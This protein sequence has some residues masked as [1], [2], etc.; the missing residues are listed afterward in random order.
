M[1]RN[2]DFRRAVDA[3]LSGLSVSP[4]K[5]MQILLRAQEEEKP[6]KKKISTSL[7]IVFAVMMLTMAAGVATTNYGVLDFNSSQKNNPAYAEH[8]LTVDQSFVGDY[9]TMTVNE[10]IFDS[11][12]LS[13]TMEIQPVADAEPV[14]IK[15]RI[16][17][18][19]GDALLET[20]IEGCRGGDFWSGFWFPQDESM[21]WGTD[22]TYGVDCAI[23]ADYE[24]HVAYDAQ[25]EP[26]TWQV[27]FDV[28]KPEWPVQVVKNQLYDDVDVDNPEE[29]FEAYIQ[30][31]KDAI[32]NHII[33]TDV[34]GGMPEFQAYLPA[35]EGMS[36]E[37]WMGLPN[38][39]Q[40][41]LSGAFSRVDMLTASFTTDGVDMLTADLPLTVDLGE[42][43]A[44]LTELNASF[45][46]VDYRFEVHKK[47][48][49]AAED[50]LNDVGIW[51]FAVISPSGGVSPMSTGGGCISAESQDTNF[52]ASMTLLAPANELT[53]V[54]IFSE[55]PQTL[56]GSDPM[57]HHVF[58]AGMPLTEEQEAMAF[59]V[60]LK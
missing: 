7:V 46:R 26:V 48:G 18:Q 39:E 52:S 31:F 14:F 53:F 12:S 49:S 44:T 38:S 11:I 22:G 23:I 20:D 1:S 8:I 6:V 27:T 10:A 60:K 55:H 42:Y 25:G 45:A 9:F 4:E 35:P 47:D 2:N 36:E 17:A 30:E 3:R 43:E 59:T 15:P 41:V 58:D 28:I 21:G 32:E 51:Q 34:Y 19:C 56:G 29:A 16:T 57:L 40:F 24:D 5:Q 33:L 50:Y 37:E 13:M 54:P